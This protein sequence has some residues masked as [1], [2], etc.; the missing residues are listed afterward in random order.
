MRSIP[1]TRPPVARLIEESRNINDSDILMQYIREITRFYS[2]EQKTSSEILSQFKKDIH[3]IIQ[4][5]LMAKMMSGNIKDSVIAKSLGIDIPIDK[6]FEKD[7]WGL[8]KSLEYLMWETAHMGLTLDKET[9][10]ALGLNNVMLKSPVEQF[11]EYGELGKLIDEFGLEIGLQKFRKMYPKENL[12]PSKILMSVY[13]CAIIFHK[14]VPEWTDKVRQCFQSRKCYEDFYSM[15]I[16]CSPY[17]IADNYF[18][19]P[20]DKKFLWN[21]NKHKALYD[22]F[23][24]PSNDSPSYNDYKPSGTLIGPRQFR[25][26]MKAARERILGR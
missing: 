10:L 20:M 16:G 22:Y 17:E 4:S 9:L 15:S 25:N 24:K 7:M 8:A 2:S 1:G 14:Q 26:I 5:Y 18:N 19:L 6:T 3:D 21:F 12:K 13:D 11:K 23:I